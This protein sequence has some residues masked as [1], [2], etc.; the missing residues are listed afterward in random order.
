VYIGHTY[1][2]SFSAHILSKVNELISAVFLPSDI[3]QIVGVYQVFSTLQSNISDEANAMWYDGCSWSSSVTNITSNINGGRCST[4]NVGFSGSIDITVKFKVVGH[5]SAVI[6]PYLYAYDDSHAMYLY[7]SNYQ[8]YS[9]I[10]SAI[11]PIQN[12]KYSG[13]Y[14]ISLSVCT[15]F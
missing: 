15:N 10:I 13:E 11:N 4:S 12:D 8:Q 14:H 5:G 1:E 6:E 7:N 2:F 9:S 3:L